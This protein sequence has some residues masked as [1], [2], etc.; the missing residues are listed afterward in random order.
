M[1]KTT[2]IAHAVALARIGNF[3]RAA[4]ELRISQAGL[5]RSIQALEN[6]L[7]VKLFDRLGSGAEVTAYGEILASRGADVVTAANDLEREIALMRGLDSGQLSVA[8]G[9]YPMA[10]TV[11]PALSRLLAERPRLRVRAKQTDWQAV[12]DAVAHQEV[13]FAIAETSY[14]RQFDALSTKVTGEHMVLFVC[15][16]EHPL[17]S[18]EKP[19][20]TDIL[21][22][23]VAGTPVPDRVAD[24]FG[25][26][27]VGAYRDTGNGPLR[28]S[29]EVDQISAALEISIRSDVVMATPL[30]L[31]EGH[32]ETGALRVIRLV[33]PW[34]R[35]S[36]GVITV[37]GRSLSPSAEALLGHV[38][39]VEAGI[40]EREKRL[41]ERW[42]PEA[43][44]SSPEPLPLS[45]ESSE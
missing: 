35:L 5:S 20:L 1:L 37:R 45:G 29:I 30:S 24:R 11:M 31:V 18:L 8:A 28:P 2:Q 43:T 39:A 4:E 19:E 21:S 6:Q 44:S 7:G 32:L 15:R 22:F 40:R 16:A 26:R 9:P 23:P 25:D 34:F 17:L 33:A 10:M 41:L 38:E 3:H 12:T 27:S 36:Y 14:A 42:Q 13:D